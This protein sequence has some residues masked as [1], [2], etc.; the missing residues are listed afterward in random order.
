MCAN[1]TARQNKISPDRR[2]LNALG[3]DVGALELKLYYLTMDL[4]ALGISLGASMLQLEELIF[5]LYI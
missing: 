5:V 4:S 2:G 1:K 3:L